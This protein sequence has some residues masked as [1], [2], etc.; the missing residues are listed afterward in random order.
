MKADIF[1]AVFRACGMTAEEATAFFTLLLVIVGALT[2]V[3]LFCQVRLLRQQVRAMRNEFI[4]S[5]RPIVRLRKLIAIPGNNQIQPLCEIVNIG[6]TQATIVDS[7]FQ[8][9]AAGSAADATIRY[10]KEAKKDVVVKI[11]LAAGESTNIAKS[12][13]TLEHHALEILRSSSGGGSY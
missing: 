1:G 8:L 11:T 3:V 2:A 4:A 5:H 12:I 13:P 9:F 6:M 7:N 10:E